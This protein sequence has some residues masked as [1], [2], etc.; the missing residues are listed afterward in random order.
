MGEMQEPRCG[1]GRSFSSDDEV[2]S[3]VAERFVG[4]KGREK[5]EL[6]ERYVKGAVN[7]GR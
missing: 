6:T 7:R 2:L 1:V 5:S 4:L 3:V